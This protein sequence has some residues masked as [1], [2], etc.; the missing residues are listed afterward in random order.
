MVDL[1]N[2]GA[3]LD[4]DEPLAADEAVAVA[5][6]ASEGLNARSVRNA[7]LG[8]GIVVALGAAA[9]AIWSGDSMP[10]TVML[11]YGMVASTLALY[12]ATATPAAQAAPV[13]VAAETTSL[14]TSEAWKLVETLTVSDASRLWCSIK[15]GAPKD[16][17]DWERKNPHYQT[18]V[19]RAS[20][21]SWANEHGHFP[22]FLQD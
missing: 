8:T 3:A 9:W 2:H 5:V 1:P 4:V 16:A 11:L 7:A 15:P 17:V 14:G 10:M 22:A 13:S 12:A 19:T 21:K 18:Q 6:H 20:L